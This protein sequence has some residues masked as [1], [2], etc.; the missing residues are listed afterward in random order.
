MVR[1]LWTA[2]SG[3]IAQ[4]TN[5]DVVSNNLSNINTT[6]FKKEGAEFKTLLY[7]T[8]QGK[9]TDTEGNPKPV[10]IQVGLGVKNSAVT[11]HYQQGPM[12]ETGNNFDFAIQGSGFFMV[13]MADG[14]TAYTRNGSFQVSMAENKIALCTSEGNPILDSEGNPIEMDA[15]YSSDKLM[16]EPDGS[17]SYP[18][19]NGKVQRLGIK[20]GLVQFPN[21]AGLEKMS[22]SLLLETGASGSP[23]IE[24]GGD[25]YTQ[26]KIVNKY[27]EGSNAQAVDEMVNMII[28]QRAYEMNS[29]A[30]TASDQMMQ[31]ANSLRG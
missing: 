17:I 8:I 11:S 6:G 9:S 16:F 30:V 24:A 12:M 20:I 19:E 25:T 26:S 28:A 31:Q 22:S 29:K 7:Q 15:T 4:Q 3:M 1:S 23:R 18:D 5:L 21:S 10:G 14:R 2:A 13:R 27:L